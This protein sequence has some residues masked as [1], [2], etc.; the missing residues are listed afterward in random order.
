MKCQKEDMNR[1]SEEKQNCL[2]PRENQHTNMT[3]LVRYSLTHET[4]FSFSALWWSARRRLWIEKMKRS[5]LVC[6]PGKTNIL[7]WQVSCGSRSRAS[8]FLRFRLMRKQV[9]EGGLRSKKWREANLFVIPRKRSW[10]LRQCKL[11]LFISI[12]SYLSSKIWA[13][14]VG[15]S[16]PFSC[17]WRSFWKKSVIMP[18]G[19]CVPKP[20][21]GE[22]AHGWGKRL[23]IFEILYLLAQA[24]LLSECAFEGVLRCLCGQP[25]APAAVSRSGQFR[26]WVKRLRICYTPS[27][28]SIRRDFDWGK[29]RT[30]CLWAIFINIDYD[31][32]LGGFRITFSYQELNFDLLS[33]LLAW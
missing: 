6:Y 28:A 10:D 27:I 32:W 31:S 8:A 23:S 5:K 1:K 25:R 4:R 26:E 9:P 14:K 18:P 2:L 12:I 30:F 7:T 20:K 13:V 24:R 17:F 29:R 21:E 16:T 15:Y 19:C 11:T 22:L 3:S 33:W